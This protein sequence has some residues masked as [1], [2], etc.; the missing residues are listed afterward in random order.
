MESLLFSVAE[1]KGKELEE[2]GYIPLCTCKNDVDDRPVLPVCGNDTRIEATV[3]KLRIVM[4]R[5]GT[6]FTRMSRWYCEY[7]SQA[8]LLPRRQMNINIIRQLTFEL[9]SIEPLFYTYQ[10]LATR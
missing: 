7:S 10:C 6:C 2:K 8:T 1:Q 4:L 5:D 9:L 3:G